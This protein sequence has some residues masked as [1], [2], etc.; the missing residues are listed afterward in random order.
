MRAYPYCACSATTYS[1]P[2]GDHDH[3]LPGE[4]A[5]S[6]LEGVP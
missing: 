5:L 2:C 6:A 3:G 1:D 4:P